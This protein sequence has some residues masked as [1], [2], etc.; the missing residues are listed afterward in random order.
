MQA[1][2]GDAMKK[3]IMNKSTTAAVIEQIKNGDVTMRPQWYFAALLVLSAAG[4]IAASLIVAYLMNVVFMWIRIQT[5]DTMAWGARAKPGAVLS[6]F[7]W[8]TVIF[9][10]ILSVVAVWLIRKQ[11]TLYRQKTTTILT[12]FLLISIVLGVGFSILG[13]GTFHSGKQND[14]QNTH[15]RSGWQ[16]TNLVK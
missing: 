11:G 6:S 15:R 7:P 4:T 14:T 12:V 8:W 10:A 5:A 16:R 13:M 2:R 3:P 1:E 9:A